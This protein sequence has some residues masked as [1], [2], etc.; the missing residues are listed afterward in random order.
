MTTLEER[1]VESNVAGLRVLLRVS[2]EQHPPDP[3]FEPIKRFMN[4]GVVENIAEIE[5]ENIV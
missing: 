4:R 2:A 1:A 3:H 5:S